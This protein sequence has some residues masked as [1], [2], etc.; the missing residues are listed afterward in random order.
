MVLESCSRNL[1]CH[2]FAFACYAWHWHWI[3]NGHVSHWHWIRFLWHLHCTDPKWSQLIKP[4]IISPIHGG[5][6]APLEST[7]HCPFNVVTVADAA[8]I[9]SFWRSSFTQAKHA[10]NQMRR[11]WCSLITI[12]HWLQNLPCLTPFTW[13]SISCP[14]TTTQPYHYSCVKCKYNRNEF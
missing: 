10:I 14:R 9:G 6:H 1:S 4:T 5:F 8:S 7:T 12:N 3:R 11:A 13:V 2:L